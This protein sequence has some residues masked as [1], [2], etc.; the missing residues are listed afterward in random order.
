VKLPASRINLLQRSHLI[1]HAVLAMEHPSELL[2]DHP[3]RRT[4]RLAEHTS[5]APVWCTYMCMWDLQSDLPPLS[6]LQDPNN[7]KIKE[8][9]DLLAELE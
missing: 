8:C 5:P 6:P 1:I 9:E 3:E 4:G 2:G 7:T